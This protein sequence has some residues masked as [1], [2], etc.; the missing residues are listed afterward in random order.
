MAGPLDGVKILELTAVV[1]GPW[2][3]Q[4]LADMGAEVIKVEPPYGDSNRS[5]GAS[6]N[7]KMSALYLT[8]N[9][10]KRSLVLDLKQ[11]EAREAV[12]KIEIGRAHV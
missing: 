8:C 9:R 1:L 12:I 11:P 3:C 10:N 7:P 5:L 4:I 6:R 2:A